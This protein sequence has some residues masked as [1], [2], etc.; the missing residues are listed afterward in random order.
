M[1]PDYRYM[2]NCMS[3]GGPGVPPSELCQSL[4]D[5]DSDQDVDLADVALFQFAFGKEYCY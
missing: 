1:L 5:L 4:C 2:D 3:G